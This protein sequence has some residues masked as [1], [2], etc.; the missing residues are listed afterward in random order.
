M[1]MAKNFLKKDI[2]VT[3]VTKVK[4]SEYGKFVTVIGYETPYPDPEKD[5]VFMFNLGLDKKTMNSL[6]GQL[7]IRED[8]LSKSLGDKIKL[9]TGIKIKVTHDH[10]DTKDGVNYLKKIYGLKFL[11]RVMGAIDIKILAKD[12]N[13]DDGKFVLETKNGKYTENKFIVKVDDLPFDP[14]TLDENAEIQVKGMARI[15]YSTFK[16]DGKWVIKPKYWYN[17]EH[18]NATALKVIA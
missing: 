10:V 13:V 17:F 12:T 11:E 15:Y 9:P 6:M 18:D 1:H 4:E 8:L 7:K 16:Q 2:V 5:E 14:N 3:N